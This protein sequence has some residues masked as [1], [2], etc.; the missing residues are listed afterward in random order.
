MDRETI[1]EI[2]RHFGVVAEHL[3][4]KVQ[5]LAEGHEGLRREIREFR[6]EVKAEFQEV[7]AMI[8]FSY[9]EL[10]RRFRTL[11]NEVVDLR[12]RVDRIEAAIGR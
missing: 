3:E 11:E 8:K 2:K 4:G 9:A 12:S 6:E 1:E 7:K 5:L 10:D